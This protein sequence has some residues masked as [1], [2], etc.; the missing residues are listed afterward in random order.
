MASNINDTGV[1]KDY[2][3]AGQDNDSQGFRDNFN[4]R[5]W[6]ITIK[7]KRVSIT[8]VIQHFFSWTKL[9]E[10]SRC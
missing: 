6:S 7:L 3:V 9:P 5:S 10:L 1:N 4:V 8:N 2:P